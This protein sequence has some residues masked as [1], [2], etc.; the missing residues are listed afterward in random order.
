MMFVIFIFGAFASNE[1]KN[2][3]FPVVINENWTVALNHA[4][5]YGHEEFMKMALNPF[6]KEEK[7]KL[8]KFLMKG[9]DTNQITALHLASLNRRERIVKLLFNAFAKE[10]KKR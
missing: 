7:K 10:D 4:A 1:M 9:N 6:C 5:K 3:Y 8:M 2:N